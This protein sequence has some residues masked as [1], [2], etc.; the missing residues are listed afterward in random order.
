VSASNDP[1]T[2]KAAFFHEHYRE[3]TR[4]RIRLELVLERLR[5]ALPPP[6]AAVLDV[7]G[8]T[9]AFA[10]PLALD[11]HDVTVLDRSEEWLDVA[12]RNARGAGVRIRLIE[13]PAESAPAL[14]PGPFDAVLCH[15]VLIY[16]DDPRR[17]LGALRE[18]AADGAILSSL[19]KNRDGLPVRPARDGDF[20]EALRVMDDPIASGR[21]GIPNRALSLGELRS[22]LASTGWLPTSWAGI[23]VFSDGVLDP[24]DPATFETVMTLDRKA[25]V[26]D[27]HRRMGRLLHVLARAWKPESLGAIQARSYERAGPGTL[28]SWPVSSALTHSA[29]DAFLERKR[30]AVLSTTRPSGRPHSTMVG[31]CIRDGRIWLPAVAGA[32]RLRNVAVEP[33]ASMLVTEGERDDHVAVLIEG[34]VAIRRDPTEALDGWLR[35]A[36]LER[37]GTELTWADAIIELLPTKVLSYS[38]R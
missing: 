22:D 37:Y 25:A 27:P 34:Q 26:R 8:G 32:Q 35:A 17:I 38:A 20:G 23:R 24:L 7:G 10:I 5:R 14:A 3:G 1:F 30:Y 18:V 19:E 6:P 13:G 15:T 33:T 21:I 4:G 29:L 11:G 2:G 9:G 36:W 28:E 12:G 31:F 16:A